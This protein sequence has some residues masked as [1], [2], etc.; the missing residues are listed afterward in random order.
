MCLICEFP[1]T[2]QD[3]ALRANGYIFDHPEH[4]P[5]VTII[6]KDPNNIATWTFV[7]NTEENVNKLMHR[8]IEQRM[9]EARLNP[10]TL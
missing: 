7:S 8:L 1:K 10:D 4:Y 3:E 6:K 2:E 5:D 9:L